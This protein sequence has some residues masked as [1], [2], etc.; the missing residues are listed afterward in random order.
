MCYFP[1]VLIT[2]SYLSQIPQDS[3]A[4]Q[5]APNLATES[6]VTPPEQP[7][8][9]EPTPESETDKFLRETADKLDK[10]PYVSAEII[11]TARLADRQI[12]STGI[13]KKG[14]DY[15]L[16]LE[17]DVDMGEATGKRVHV[18]N[19]EIG[20][21]YEK[22]IN[23]ETLQSVE[24][25][26]VAQMLETK[27]LPPENKEQLLSMLPYAKPGDMLRGYLRTLTFTE[28]KEGTLGKENPRDVLIVEGNWKKEVLLSITGSEAPADLEDMGQNFPQ[29]VRVYLDKETGW[30]LRTELFR[31]DERAVYKP[32]FVL[33][34]LKV[35]F[36]EKLPSTDFAYEIPKGVEPQ[37]TTPSWISLLN[38]LPDKAGA[39]TSVSPII[40]PTKKEAEQEQQ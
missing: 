23:V 14:P 3:Q 32:I 34:F 24:V 4:S 25:G 26:E 37:D 27:E 31:R 17:L 13:Y 6:A 18:C 19:G 12:R 2:L 15:R 1:F 39:G 22:I 35:T 40:K 36:A 29:F 28:K 5:P 7:P 33:E 11:Q 10:I 20:Y 30:P 38:S 21:R 9:P 8:Q 16:R